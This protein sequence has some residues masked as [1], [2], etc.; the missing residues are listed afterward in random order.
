[1]TPRRQ[2]GRA[3]TARPAPR[4]PLPAIRKR[5]WE[6][7]CDLVAAGDTRDLAR[8][9]ANR[10]NTGADVIDVVLVLEGCR[11]QRGAAALKTGVLNALALAREAEDAADET[12]LSA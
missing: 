9:L 3:N 7:A 10:W 2:P 6:Q 11:F 8:V 1:M 4:L 12:T 5:I